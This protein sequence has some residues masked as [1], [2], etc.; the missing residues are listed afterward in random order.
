MRVT[1]RAF[2]NLRDYAPERRER[3][4][5][6]LAHGASVAAVLAAMQLPPAVQTVLL[7]NGRRAGAATALADGDE[8]T[9]F[10]PMEG[11]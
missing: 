2:A 4:E 8:I 9:L 3:F 10:P 7:V 6:K 5:L 11:G 1:V